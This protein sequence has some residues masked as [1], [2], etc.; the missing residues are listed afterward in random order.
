MKFKKGNYLK[1]VDGMNA[2]VKVN[3]I[4]ASDG[5]AVVNVIDSSNNRIV[6]IKDLQEYPISPMFFRKLGTIVIESTNEYND[7][8]FLIGAIVYAFEKANPFICNVLVKEVETNNFNK[9]SEITTVTEFQDINNQVEYGVP[10]D[11]IRDAL[12]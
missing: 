10:D 3:E 12:K 6:A 1:L 4:D 5:K 9:V 2:L 11:I 8:L 7:I